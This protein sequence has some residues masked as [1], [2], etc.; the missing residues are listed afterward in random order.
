MTNNKDKIKN[1]ADQAKGKT[2][3]L[4]GQVSG[5]EQAE[6]NGKVTYK[7]AT[8]KEDVNKKIDETRDKMKESVE[9]NKEKVAGKINDKLDEKDDQQ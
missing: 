7:K 3:E 9:K 5:S 2:K 4:Y 6:L 1:K 8:A